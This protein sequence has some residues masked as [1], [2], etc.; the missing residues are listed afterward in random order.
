MLLVPGCR[1]RFYWKNDVNIRME[2]EPHIIAVQHNPDNMPTRYLPTRKTLLQAGLTALATAVGTRG[3]LYSAPIMK[4]M[5][6]K[7]LPR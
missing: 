2:L 6:A 5:N 3:G 1:P 4:L 7:V